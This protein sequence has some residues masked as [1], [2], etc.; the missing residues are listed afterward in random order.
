MF[1]TPGTCPHCSAQYNVTACP[2]CYSMRPIAE[3]SG[4]QAAQ[5]KL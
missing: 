1:L 4:A 5:P 2:F 3:W